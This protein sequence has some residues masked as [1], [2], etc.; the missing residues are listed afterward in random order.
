M[1]DDQ[2][3]LGREGVLYYAAAVLT[4]TSPHTP[5]SAT[6]LELGEVIDLNEDSSADPIKTTTRGNKRKHSYTTSHTDESIDFNVLAKVGN[7]GIAAFRTAYRTGVPIAA[8]SLTDEKT[9]SGATGPVGNWVVT[10]FST[11]KP[12]EGTQQVDISLKPHSE[13]DDYTVT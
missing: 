9:V 11:K 2:S 3:P 1:Q 10:K 12:L 8:M 5:S 13:M 6:W 4:G 7:A